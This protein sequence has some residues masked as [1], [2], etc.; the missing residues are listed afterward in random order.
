MRNKFLFILLLFVINLGYSA[1]NPVNI[2]RICNDG[3]NV[4]LYWYRTTDTCNVFSNYY[5]WARNGTSGP[6]SL[7]DSISNISAQTY[8]HINANVGA[9]AKNWYYC[10]ENVD[11]CGLKHY[12]FSDTLPVN[13]SPE[14]QSVI[15]S[16]SVDSA[17]KVI[18]GWHSNYSK[19]FSHYIVYLDSASKGKYKSI[20]PFGNKDTFIV[21][22][23]FYS[24]PSIG[25]Q[26]YDLNV[27]DSCDNVGFFGVNP[28]K[29][30]YLTTQTDTC[31]K[32]T[33]LIWTPYVGWSKIKNYYIFK[34]INSGLTLLLDSTTENILT[35]SEQIVLGDTI[36]FY[37]RAIKDTTNLVTSTSNQKKINTRFRSEPKNISLLNV[38]VNNVDNTPIKVEVTIKPEDEWKRLNI[39][40]S[41]DGISYLNIG[42]INNVSQLPYYDNIDASN[43]SFKY[44]I[45]SVN[46]CGTITLETVASN[47]I[48]LKTI[49]SG[50]QNALFW[51]KYNYWDSGVEKYIIYRGTNINSDMITYE[52][53]D[54]VSSA[55]SVYIDKKPSVY[56]GSM[57][58]CYYIVAKQSAKYNF[59][60]SNHSCIVGEPLVY[61]PNAFNPQGINTTFQPGGSYI[62]YKKSN[63]EVYDRWGGEVV[64]IS[65]LTIGW[66]GKDIK[67]QSCVQ[68]V[69]FYKMTIIGTNGSEKT[70]TGTVTLLN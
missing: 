27:V 12:Q 48:F 64:K 61:I 35:Y 23:F 41:L 29:T 45:Q 15:D 16:V 37:I 55:D 33:Q 42:T 4:T 50:N 38:S 31:K 21:D 5:I 43:N 46:L 68:G 25:S 44:K 3:L 1:T 60:Y 63:L 6:F 70:K 9:G 57:G 19:N 39:L 65:D 11:F 28:H 40:R 59:S 49:V 52:L 32:T 36:L 54:S 8:T 20:N 56:I 53:I 10:I 58:I 14:Y 13:I 18:I 24:D 47:S 30:I 66:D 22:T 67:G 34:K 2:R 26:K 62:D 69:Y 17:N 51:D 7:I